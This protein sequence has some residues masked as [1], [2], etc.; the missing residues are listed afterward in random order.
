MKLT[1]Q[2]ILQKEE[3][4]KLYKES[5]P[6]AIKTK[7]INEAQAAADAAIKK[8]ADAKKTNIE[9]HEADYKKACEAAVKSAEDIEKEQNCCN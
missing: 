8:L 3:S 7:I 9:K 4:D 6:E 2:I 1:R 5:D